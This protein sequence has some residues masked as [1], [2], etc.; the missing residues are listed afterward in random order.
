MLWNVFAEAGKQTLVWHWPGSSWPPTSDSPNLHVVP[1][2]DE[3]HFLLHS[4]PR[5]FA[6]VR[7]SILS[8]NQNRLRHHHFLLLHFLLIEQDIY[9]RVAIYK[10][11]KDEQ[12]LAIVHE[13]EFVADIIDEVVV[14]DKHIPVNRNMKL[15]AC[16][17]Q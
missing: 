17:W 4:L 2:K 13:Q 12:P 1:L 5:R 16:H 7:L 3:F 9:D 6:P 11:K 14:D 15:L 10:S 8:R